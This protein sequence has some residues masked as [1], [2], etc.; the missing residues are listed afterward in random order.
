[1]M[2]VIHIVEQMS[3]TEK[4]NADD[5]TVGY[6]GGRISALEVM[7]TLRS[8]VVDLNAKLTAQAEENDALLREINKATAGRYKLISNLETHI[9]YSRREM[10]HV[11][12]TLAACASSDH[13]SRNRATL[14][15]IARLMLVANSSYDGMDDDEIPF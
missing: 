15:V 9:N 14:A 2:D 12:Q 10:R 5:L 6:D 4:E 3:D 7:E 1:M 8:A 11:C 13:G